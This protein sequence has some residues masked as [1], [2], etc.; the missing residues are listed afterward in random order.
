[1]AKY[2]SPDDVYRKLVDESQDN[3]LLGLLAFA[4]VEQQRIEWAKHRVEIGG[5]P[6]TTAD[7][8]AWYESQPD[9]T[10]IRAKAEAETALETFGQEAVEQFDD[11]YRKEIATGIVINEIQKLGKWWPQLGMNVVGGLIGSLVFTALLIVVAFFVLNE[12]STNDIAQKLQQKM[13]IDDEQV[14]GN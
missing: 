13:E 14:R 7:V 3:W 9:S 5:P 12:P 10:L 11:A 2:S 8:T 6:P 4:I 1:M